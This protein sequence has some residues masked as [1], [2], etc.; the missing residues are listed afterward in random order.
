[1]GSGKHRAARVR[2]GSR[3]SR[4]AATKLPHDRSGRKPNARP[5]ARI[6]KERTQARGEASQ[7]RRSG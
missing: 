1:M 6:K 2:L 4:R 7:S 5:W 3:V